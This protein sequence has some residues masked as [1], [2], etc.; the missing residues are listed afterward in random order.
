MAV[1]RTIENS[2]EIIHIHDDY[3]CNIKTKDISQILVQIGVLVSNS[4][5]YAKPPGIDV[6]D[7]SSEKP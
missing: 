5:C 6:L 3:C 7:V 1:L 4:Y 2:D